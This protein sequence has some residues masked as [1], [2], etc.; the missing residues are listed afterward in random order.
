MNQ[1]ILLL[2]LH[3]LVIVIIN[4]NNNNDRIK[5]SCRQL[6]SGVLEVL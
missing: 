4:N 3:L 6:F 5:K 2:R 1:C